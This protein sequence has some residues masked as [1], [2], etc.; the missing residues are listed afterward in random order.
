MSHKSSLTKALTALTDGLSKNARSRSVLLELAQPRGG[1]QYHRLLLRFL[2]AVRDR[3]PFQPKTPWTREINPTDGTHACACATLRRKPSRVTHA[4]LAF[5]SKHEEYTY[6]MIVRYHGETVP[7]SGARK[8]P[9]VLHSKSILKF[10]RKH[11]CS[12]V[13]KQPPR[14]QHRNEGTNR[15]ETNKQTNVPPC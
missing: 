6:M 12:I 10:G 13:T 11:V 14:H 8:S 2:A 3:D 1:L 15:Y 9:L 4:W 5:A 7:G